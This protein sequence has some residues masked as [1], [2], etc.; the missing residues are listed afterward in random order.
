MFLPGKLIRPAGAMTLRIWLSFGLRETP[1]G[2]CA[3]GPLV[4]H[5][6]FCGL[7]IET[8]SQGPRRVVN[9]IVRRLGLC[10]KRVS[11]IAIPQRR[12]AL[13]NASPQPLPTLGPLY[14]TQIPAT[15][16]VDNR[17]LSQLGMAL[18]SKS[19][20]ETLS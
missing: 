11:H 6:R 10:N 9:L 12:N 1:V 15:C 17:C 16:Y 19:T 13:Q 5:A 18:A 8:P 14:I 4:W 2:Y 3:P 20:W 7:G